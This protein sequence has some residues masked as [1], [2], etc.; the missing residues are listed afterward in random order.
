M[1]CLHTAF[2]RPCSHT[3]P[4]AHRTHLMIGI[5]CLQKPALRH[6]TQLFF[7][8]PCGHRMHSLHRQLGSTPCSHGPFTGALRLKSV[9]ASGGGPF[10]AF[11]LVAGGLVG[12]IAALG[13]LDLAAGFFATVRVALG[14]GCAATFFGFTAAF[15]GA[16]FGG[17]AGLALGFL[18]LKL[19][20]VAN[21]F[22][23]P[24]F[25]AIP[26]ASGLRAGG[27]GAGLGGLGLGGAAFDANFLAAPGDRDARACGRSLAKRGLLASTRKSSSS[28]SEESD[29]SAGS[30]LCFFGLADGGLA[31]E[32]NF[33]AAV[34]L[35]L[36]SA[37]LILTPVTP[38]GPRS[39]RRLQNSSDYIMLVSSTCR[40]SR[41]W[42]HPIH[43]RRAHVHRLVEI[44]E[45]CRPRP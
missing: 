28:V 39:G 8:F 27:G 22:A 40:K 44:V 4:P 6:R 13:A 42:L 1:H 21:F 12:C 41:D 37:T 26:F 17:G 20:L 14:L 11:E 10:L 32:A 23:A 36:M 15:V 35:L 33:L 7:H 45:R 5:L 19:A 30:R 38:A 3:N 34:I 9:H 25:S 2:S 31:F 24:R 43:T 16:G 29:T 18:A